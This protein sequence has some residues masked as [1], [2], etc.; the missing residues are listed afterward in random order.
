M[1]TRS[2]T[3]VY[4]ERRYIKYKNINNLS[5][6]ITK[7]SLVCNCNAILY[8]YMMSLPLVNSSRLAKNSNILNV[9]DRVKQ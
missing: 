1:S 9:S 4:V 2:A 5:T 3:G 7:N 8:Y 6:L